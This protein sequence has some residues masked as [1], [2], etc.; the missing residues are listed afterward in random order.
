M[1]WATIESKEA[2]RDPNR[3]SHSAYASMEIQFEV[4]EVRSEKKRKTRS[5]RSYV[6]SIF[7]I[8]RNRGDWACKEDTNFNF[9]VIIIRNWVFF[10]YV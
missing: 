7:K 8:Y 9:V 4:A 1:F 10:A 6:I 3:A 5:A 2:R